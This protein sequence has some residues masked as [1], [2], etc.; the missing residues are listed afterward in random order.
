MK[1]KLLEIE[2]YSKIISEIERFIKSEKEKPTTIK[3]KVIGV[4]LS[5]NIIN[6]E[7]VI[8]KYPN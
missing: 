3:G 4:D 2:K 1:T 5:N 8:N 6:V 7:I